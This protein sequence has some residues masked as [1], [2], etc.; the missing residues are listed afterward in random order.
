VYGKRLEDKGLIPGMGKY[1]SDHHSIQTD[2]ASHP[3]SNPMATGRSF[4]EGK[5]DEF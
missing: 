5:A 4:P 2:T 3:A 1:F